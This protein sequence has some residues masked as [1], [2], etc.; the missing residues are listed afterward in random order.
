METHISWV[1]LAG[2]FAWK[3]KK[4]VCFDFLDFSSLDRRRHFCEREIELN[5]RTAPE[6]YLD[7]VPICGT[8][9]EPEVSGSNS[10]C[11][12]PIEYAV[13][14][15]RFDQEQ[16][17]LNL[18]KSGELGSDD[19]DLL[20]DAVAKFHL[21]L[22][23]LGGET[24]W[25]DGTEI[26]S[27]AEGNFSALREGGF[28][29]EGLARIEALAGWTNESMCS[30]D[31]WFQV[32]KRDGFVREC[33]GDLHLRNIV[34]Y[35]GRP[36]LFDCLE[37]NES[38][39]CIDVI[40]DLAFLISD[41]AD[42]GFSGFSWRLLNRWLE[43]TGDYTAITGLNFYIVYRAMVRAK[44]NALRL[45]DAELDPSI[46]DAVRGE[47]RA[48]LDYAEK[49][50]RPSQ[51]R[52]FIMHGLSGSGKTTVASRLI[53]SVGAVRIRS[54]VERKRLAGILAP[55]GQQQQ[56]ASPD[57]YSKEF[58][59]RTYG[60]LAT[61]ANDL[62]AAGHQ[63]IVDAAF[64]KEQQRAQFAEVAMR[65]D[66]PFHI[67]SCEAPECVLQERLIERTSVF[68]EVSDAGVDELR[69]QFETQ[70][71]L[72]AEERRNEIHAAVNQAEV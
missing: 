13:K 66:A 41:L 40:N 72:T 64:L 70:E 34:R 5:R 68:A 24:H 6:L 58:T 8:P 69:L 4:P 27:A 63:V 52:L 50:I 14:M 65:H 55:P 22:P 47:L 21:S 1:F 53:E 16:L 7:V 28:Q 30:L 37:F 38:F 2:E 43:A 33:H 61:L 26:R 17:F 15:R 71:P 59:Q 20:A 44:V 45:R 51:P 18:A 39:R 60:R 56:K 3:I 29:A 31:P 42:H 62:L 23:S 10:S 11:G 9:T 46:K 54:D 25:G 48:F 57:F 32:R 12:E 35:D 67:V 36:C 19:I 49:T